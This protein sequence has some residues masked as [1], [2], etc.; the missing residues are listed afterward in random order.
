MKGAVKK[1]FWS[2]CFL[3]F[4]AFALVFD[5]PIRYLGIPVIPTSEQ[6]IFPAHKSNTSM[7]SEITGARFGN[8]S[9]KKDRRRKRGC[10]HR[11]EHGLAV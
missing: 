9:G 1:L 11:V 6:C 2:F 8:R 4:A 7:S 3:V 5:V 10:R